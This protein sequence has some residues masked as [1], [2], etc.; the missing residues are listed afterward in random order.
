VSDQIGLGW[1]VAA[2]PSLNRSRFGRGTFGLSV[3]ARMG[4]NDCF[5]PPLGP[6][7]DYLYLAA[8]VVV[9]AVALVLIFRM[10]RTVVPGWKYELSRGGKIVMVLDKPGFYMVSPFVTAKRVRNSDGPAPK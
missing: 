1:W 7:M 3:G 2:L 4:N 5:Y 10:A 6:R 8:I 9:L